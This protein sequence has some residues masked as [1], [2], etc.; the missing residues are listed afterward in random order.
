MTGR[1]S[2]GKKQ[3]L[4]RIPVD[5]FYRNP[6]PCKLIARSPLRALEGAHAGVCACLLKFHQLQ[7][8]STFGT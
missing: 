7:G 5:I 1:K 8:K 6:R 4:Q 2:G 3:W